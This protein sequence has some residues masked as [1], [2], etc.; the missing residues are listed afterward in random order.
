MRPG[1][2]RVY[3]DTRR[4]PVPDLPVDRQAYRSE[5]QRKLEEAEGFAFLFVG[6]IFAFILTI[7]VA[8]AFMYA[9]THGGKAHLAP[10]ATPYDGQ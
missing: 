4:A 9:P 5:R 2:D 8:V 10:V 7:G 1:Y 3:S 6:S